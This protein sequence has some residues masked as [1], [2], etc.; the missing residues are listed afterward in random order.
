VWRTGKSVAIVGSEANMSRIRRVPCLRKYVGL[1]ATVPWRR[2][3]LRT[4]TRSVCILVLAGCVLSWP[5]SADEPRRV[6]AIL[7]TARAELPDP[8]FRDSVVLVMNNLGPG[9]AGV[10][11]N[12]PTRIAVSHLFPDVGRLAQSDDKVYFGGPVGIASLVF[13]FRAATPPEH[14]IEVI[15]GVYLSADAALLRKLLDREK[16]MEGLR[17]FIGYSSWGPGQLEGEIARGDW[18]LAPATSKTI[19]AERPGHPWPGQPMPDA[20]HSI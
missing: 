20:A 4:V 3:R 15:D 5:A 18:T 19:F 7:V 14:A 6:T 2:P 12:R 17:M 8:N 1:V 11:L 10:I 16:P 13:L 9:P